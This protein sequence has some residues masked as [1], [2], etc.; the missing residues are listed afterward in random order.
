MPRLVQGV[1]LFVFATAFREGFRLFRLVRLIRL[2]LVTV[3]RL[4][5]SVLQ[6]PVSSGRID[7]LPKMRAALG[8][9]RAGVS[10][11]HVRRFRLERRAVATWGMYVVA[12]YDLN[13][14]HVSAQATL[15]GRGLIAPARLLA[16]GTTL[17]TASENETC[18]PNSLAPERT[19]PRGHFLRG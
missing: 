11:S 1:A 4:A 16:Y 18:C 2:I 14:H 17:N 9:G 10:D 6:R 8:L 12:Q 3:R 13:S 19:E 15:S 5:R 7:P